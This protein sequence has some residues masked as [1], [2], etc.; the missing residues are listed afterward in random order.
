MVKQKVDRGTLNL[1]IHL[2]NESNLAKF[3]IVK[4]S[5]IEKWTEAVT[6]FLDCCET[7]DVTQEQYLPELVKETY[8]ELANPGGESNYDFQA[9][10]VEAEK[11]EEK[12]E[13]QKEHIGGEGF[14]KLVRRIMRQ[15]DMHMTYVMDKMLVE[16][17]TLERIHRRAADVSLKMGRKSML[18]VNDVRHHIK[19]RRKCGWIFSESLTGEIKLIGAAVKDKNTPLM[20]SSGTHEY[21]EVVAEDGIIHYEGYVYKDALKAQNE[22]TEQGVKWELRKSYKK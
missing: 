14:D 2:L 19:W 7:V 1:A 4:A 3:R 5:L 12:E 8:N 15:D 21:F 17:A 13:L 6:R 10:K 11:K 18:H 20:A 16:G 22:L 9:A